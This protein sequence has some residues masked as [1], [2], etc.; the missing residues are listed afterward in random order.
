ML[1]IK[2][3]DII[4]VFPFSI[5][6]SRLVDMVSYWFILLTGL[7]I[8]WLRLSRFNLLCFSSSI[9]E[10]LVGFWWIIYWVMIC[11][12]DRQVISD[13]VP[14]VV[15][16]EI[17]SEGFLF[18]LSPH[19]DYKVDHYEEKHYA[20]VYDSKCCSH[21]YILMITKK[22][23]SCSICSEY[24]LGNFFWKRYCLGKLR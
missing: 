14:R 18:F 13:V 8:F 7:F 24:L 23:G 17:S 3:P 16:K 12:D 21:H 1:K 11:E 20:K 10:L 15:T 4:I 6:T 5:D 22:R 9:N 19:F 2:L